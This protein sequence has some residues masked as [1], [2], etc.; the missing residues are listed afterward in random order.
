MVLDGIG[1]VETPPY[2]LR[3]ST[4][5]ER[6][7]QIHPFYAKR[8]QF[9]PKQANRNL[10]QNKRLQK[11]TSIFGPKTTKPI[12]R[13]PEMSVS[14]GITMNYE[15]KTMNYA[16]KN[17]PKRTQNEPNFRKAKK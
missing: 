16:N 10:L 2:K 5:V 4:F 11:W 7:L 3:C 6:P 15:Q 8:T 1:G 14:S 13:T 17:E 9:S 12:L